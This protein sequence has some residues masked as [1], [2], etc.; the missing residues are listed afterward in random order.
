MSR[1]MTLQK[2]HWFCRTGTQVCH[3]FGGKI[4]SLTIFVAGLIFGYM[5]SLCI[6]CLVVS[7]QTAVNAYLQH[8]DSKEYFGYSVDGT[9]RPV[10]PRFGISWDFVVLFSLTEVNLRTIK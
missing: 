4:G 5:Q 6:K 9:L 1:L 10:G 2:C 7:E 3:V 8:S